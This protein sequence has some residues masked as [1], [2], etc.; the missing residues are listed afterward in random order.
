[1]AGVTYERWLFR[2]GSNYTGLLFEGKILA[3]YI[4]EAI[5]YERKSHIHGGS[6][7]LIL[8]KTFCRPEN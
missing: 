8:C 5:A 2:R 6:I 3:D 4:W 1:M 7:V